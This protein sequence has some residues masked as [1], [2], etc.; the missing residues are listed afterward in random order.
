[1][2]KLMVAL[3]VTVVAVGLGAWLT[4]ASAWTVTVSGTSECVN[5]QAVVHWS[6][7][8]SEANSTMNITSSNNP[9]VP[10]GTT[11]AGGQTGQFD[12]NVDGPG[13][14]TLDVAASW[15][16]SAETSDPGPVSVEVPGDCEPEEPPVTEP[17]T[18]EPPTTPPA[19]PPSTP[20]AVEPPVG[21]PHV[22][23]T[24]V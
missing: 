15:E 11:V 14:Y 7:K 2:K 3:V 9:A 1:M 23:N 6:V 8:N 10:V 4:P 13:T 5:G 21:T 20:P 16:G 17:P 19:E 22:P 18:P 24:G 12:Q